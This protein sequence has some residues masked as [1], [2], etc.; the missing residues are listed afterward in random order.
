[1]LSSFMT[2]MLS[3]HC[4][5]LGPFHCLALE[6]TGLPQA[7]TEIWGLK[8]VSNRAPESVVHLRFAGHHVHEVPRHHAWLSFSGLPHSAQGQPPDRLTLAQL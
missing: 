8:G 7:R 4:G 1:M 2:L 6:E 3:V 5:V